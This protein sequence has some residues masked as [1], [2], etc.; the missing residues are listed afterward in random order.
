MNKTQ[1]ES[2][3]PAW[4][5]I[6]PTLAILA[7]A[8]FLLFFGLGNNAFWDDE[9]N[10]ALFARNL[11]KCGHLTAWDGSNVIGF[12]QGAELDSHLTNVYMPPIQYHVA[13]WGLRLWG[14]TTVGG[15]LPFVLL[16]LCSIAMLVLF[17]RWHYEGKVKEWL[18]ALL[19]ALNPAYLM[20]M[21]QC[22][23]YAIVC[24][25]TL[26]ILALLSHPKQSR[27]GQ[28]IAGVLGCVAAV[29]LMFTNYMNAVA[30]GAILPLFFLLG[31]YR[32]RRN[33]WYV[34]AVISVLVLTGVYVLATANPLGISVSYKSAVTG[35]H[36]A[37]LLFW[38]HVSDL[39]RFE[40]F[41][42]ITLPLLVGL[43]L[44]YRR[45][46][47]ASLVLDALLICGVL[48]VY[49][50]AI[51]AFSPQT[52]VA[53]T[54]VADMR[55]VVV[56]APIGAMATA[57]ALTALW[58]MAKGIGPS[59]A[60]FSGA[61]LVA[62][63][64]FTSA[65]AHWAPLRST[66][67]DYIRENARN[68]TTGN[69]AIIHYLKGLPAGQVIRV[70]P[71]YMTYPA[72]FYVP[73]QHYCCQL[74]DDHPLDETLRSQLPDYVYLTRVLPDYILVG[75][76]IEPQQLMLQCAAAFG[77]GKYR[78]G[79][80]VGSDYRDASRPEIPWHSFGPRADGRG[81]LVLQRVATPQK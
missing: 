74:G 71:D 42:V 52:V 57:V 28:W 13:A 46:P 60:L 10:T 12:R 27:R 49:S 37:A 78:L 67:F 29:L 64:L 40:F 70:I 47:I 16:G 34:V 55:Y 3:V 48:V 32:S 56:L 54:V 61:A 66:L 50:A 11:I 63:N 68:Y 81:F 33:S 69:E 25:L 43:W 53:S 26:L 77:A 58:G 75:G 35:I 6:L 41:P 73:Q 79:P 30:L 14:Y 4:Q 59:L 31:R 51:V 80:I 5:G 17:T 22:R 65:V 9:A 15:R 38:W 44:L 72:M 39:P 1:F 19:V 23:Y 7:T 20:F 21:R 45:T 76:D 36:R 62:T 24:L 18:P 8:A 2:T